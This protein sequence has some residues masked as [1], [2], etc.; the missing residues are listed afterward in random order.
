MIETLEKIRQDIDITIG[1]L[2]PCRYHWKA[3]AGLL[4]AGVRCLRYLLF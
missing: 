3:N 2:G 4:I 1:Q